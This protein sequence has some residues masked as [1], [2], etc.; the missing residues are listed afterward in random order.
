MGTLKGATTQN[1]GEW[2][3]VPEEYAKSNKTD[4]DADLENE[5]RKAIKIFKVVKKWALS[6]IIGIECDKRN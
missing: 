3:K 6:S 4:P 5:K 2:L 1:G